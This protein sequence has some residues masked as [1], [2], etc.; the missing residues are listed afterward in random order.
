MA[1][2]GTSL[3]RNILESSHCAISRLSEIEV[4][5]AV[6]RR[7]REGFFT[8][9]ERDRAL[10]SFHDHVSSFTIVELTPSVSRDAA[11]LLLRYTLRSGDAIQLASCLYLQRETQEEI[12]FGAFDS[13]LNQAA[14]SE[15]LK[16]L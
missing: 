2:A 16:L 4:A 8:T 15:G 14:R 12:T 6:I 3:V 11:E 7:S 5:S 10:A 13:R 1:E 9:A